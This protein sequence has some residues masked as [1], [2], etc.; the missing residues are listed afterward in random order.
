MINKQILRLIA[1][2]L[3]VLSPLTQADLIYSEGETCH[4]YTDLVAVPTKTALITGIRQQIKPWYM[5]RPGA[6]VKPL[7]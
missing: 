5:S 6:Q 3:L 7:V 4:K 2:N 1:V